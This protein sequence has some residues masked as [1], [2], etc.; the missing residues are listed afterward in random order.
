MLIDQSLH[1]LLEAAHSGG[2]E[3]FDGENPEERFPGLAWA[4]E[5][6]L[7][8]DVSGGFHFSSKY[9]LT[10]KGLRATGLPAKPQS[11]WRRLL[12]LW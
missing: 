6:G 11:I 12:Q 1:S 10:A 7:V 5:Q 9:I 4:I 2:V 8:K 3:V